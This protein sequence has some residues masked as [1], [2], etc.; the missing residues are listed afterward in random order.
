MA[1]TR[2]LTEQPA[3][4]TMDPAAGTAKRQQLSLIAN[5]FRRRR[6]FSYRFVVTLSPS[7]CYTFILLLSYYY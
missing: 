2:T 5:Q 1:A 4:T 6:L 3:A 7:L